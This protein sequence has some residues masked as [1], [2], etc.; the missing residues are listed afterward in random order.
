MKLSE[1]ILCT[2]EWVENEIQ[3]H[4]DTKQEVCALMLGLLRKKAC[5]LHLEGVTQQFFRSTLG[6]FNATP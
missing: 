6:Y 3:L 1:L 5:G 4:P 2:V